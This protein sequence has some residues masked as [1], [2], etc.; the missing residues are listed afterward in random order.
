MIMY[1]HVFPVWDKKSNLVQSINHIWGYLHL[2]MKGVHLKKIHHDYTETPTKS[3]GIN[4][5][6]DFFSIKFEIKGIIYD[7]SEGY[8]V[9]KRSG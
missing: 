6:K 9:S 1:L 5:A 3:N 8:L 2:N 7:S 4:M